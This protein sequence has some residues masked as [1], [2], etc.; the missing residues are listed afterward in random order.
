[1]STVHAVLPGDVDDPLH[2][3]GGNTYDREVCAGL[4]ALGWTVHE[5]PVRG[6]WP[7]PDPEAR[8]GLATTFAGVPDDSV[9]LVDGLVAIAAPTQT[10]VASE[11]LRLVVLVHMVG[12]ADDARAERVALL[13]ASA[14][15]TTSS[16]TREQLL[17]RHD[18][19]ADQVHVAE[20]GVHPA[21]LTV[22]STAGGRLLCVGPVSH[23][24]GHDVLLDALSSI[25]DLAWQCSCVGPVDR[26]PELVRT[27]RDRAEQPDLADRV[28][29]TGPA[30]VDERYA[31]A[32]LLVHPTRDDAFAMVVT[33]ALA[34][35]VPVLASDVGG[36]P[37][38]LGRA[39][40]GARPGLL[41]APGN[42][43]ALAAGLR[44]WL[45]DTETRESWRGAAGRRRPELM[46]WEHTVAEVARVLSEV[47]HDPPR[48]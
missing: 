4:A 36:V 15:I 37:S 28:S 11:R 9:L 30:D 21:D 16:W 46:P 24:K 25:T 20:P 19:R 18:L 39:A 40:D 23:G 48:A 1:M 2:P 8:A 35:G 42:A 44:R 45:D 31:D 14:V 3:S 38:A 6:S 43:D 32:D 7:H 10:A 13:A 17:D 33:E 47:A 5:H 26:D 12:A 34:R 41:V 27:F 29:F 22:G